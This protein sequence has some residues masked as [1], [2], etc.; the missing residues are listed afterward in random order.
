MTVVLVSLQLQST[1]NTDKVRAA[2][3]GLT[4][5]HHVVQGGGDVAAWA[6]VITLLVTSTILRFVICSFC[7]NIMLVLCPLE[8]MGKR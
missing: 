1:R 2:R 4:M 8:M 7:L 5:V 6:L 3:L